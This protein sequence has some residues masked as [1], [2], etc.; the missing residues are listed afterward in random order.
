MHEISDE[1]SVFEGRVDEDI[2]ALGRLL[3]IRLL[4]EI[5][6]VLV[7]LGLLLLELLQC[8]GCWL[9]FEF[10]DPLSDLRLILGHVLLDDGFLS[11]RNQ[12]QIPWLIFGELRISLARH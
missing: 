12:L 7:A 11:V 10:E 4:G 2:A 3:L 8:F 6:T 5:I 9:L 1:Q